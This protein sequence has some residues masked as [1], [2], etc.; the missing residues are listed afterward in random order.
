MDLVAEL[1]RPGALGGRGPIDLRVTHASWVFI[2][3]ED[4]WKVKRPVTFGFLDFGSAAARRHFCEEEVRLNR[5]LAPEVYLG[6]EPIRRLD[7]V[8]SVGRDDLA[9]TGEIVDWAVHMRRLPEEASGAALLQRGA[10]RPTELAALAERLAVFHK[11]SPE[12]PDVGAWGILR[13]N[14]D[15]NFAETE[16]FVGDLVDRE[17]FEEARLFQRR[18]LS[19]HDELVRRRQVEGRVRE[20]H[21]DL[22]LEHV[23]F[24]P[25]GRGHLEPVVIDCVEFN[26]RFRCG[27][28]AGDVGFLA[29]ELDAERHPELAAGFLAHYAEASDDFELYAV[30]DFYLS[31]RAW[32]RGK[33]AALVASDV[34]TSAEVGRAKRIEAR[35]DFAL[36]RSYAGRSLDPAFVVAVGGMIG[37]GKSTLAAALGRELAVPVVS[38]DRTRKVLAGLAPTDPGGPELYTDASG[39][40]TY[41]EVLRRADAILRSGRNV[42]LDAS[43]AEP[44]WRAAAAAVARDRGATFAFIE[45]TCS[46]DDV[47]RSRLQGRRGVASTSDATDAELE[48]FRRR[49]VSP[50]DSEDMPLI[51]VEGNADKNQ[52]RVRALDALRR[53]GVL[54][55]SARTRS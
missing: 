10:L 21:G 29:M 13:M 55:A 23:Y 11:A 7:D 1:L 51:R 38:S 34:T 9:A 44:R 16:R 33:V 6:V 20:G 25:D 24:M 18:W 45:V 50:T 3:G 14:V 28:V 19:A 35:R 39:D 48:D 2:R 53:L 49:Y 17:T 22:R 41:G 47:L 37:A 30:L 8:L 54:H 42:V 27:D 43:F 15:E 12:T 5:R 36:A 4:V 31:Y 32:I 40:R 46:D 26:E 52:L